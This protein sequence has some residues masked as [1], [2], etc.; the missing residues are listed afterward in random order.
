[1]PPIL[2]DPGS[3]FFPP[4]QTDEVVAGLS[5]SAVEAFLAFGSSGLE[6]F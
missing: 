6:L 3:D 2:E 4:V 1:L 5:E